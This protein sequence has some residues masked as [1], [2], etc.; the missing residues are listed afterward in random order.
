VTL[1]N[2]LAGIPQG[3]MAGERDAPDDGAPQKE[4]ARRLLRLLNIAHQMATDRQTRVQ[5]LIDTPAA[6]RAR[7]RFQES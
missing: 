3:L 6:K 5:D 4:E 2:S 7:M 1:D